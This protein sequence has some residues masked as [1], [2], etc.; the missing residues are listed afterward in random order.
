LFTIFGHKFICM[1][2]GRGIHWLILCCKSWLSLLQSNFG[3]WI[4]IESIADII[5]NA[6]LACRALAA[7]S[8]GIKSRIN[9]RIIVR[10]HSCCPISSITFEWGIHL[11]LVEFPS[12]GLCWRRIFAQHRFGLL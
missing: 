3:L 1:C 5:Y 7:F 11:L 9:L 8:S 4:V 2:K 6:R 10:V 12:W